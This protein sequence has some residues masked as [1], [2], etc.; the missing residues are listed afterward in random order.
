MRQIKERN[1]AVCII[2]SIVTCGIYAI[3]WLVVM[4]DDLNAVSGHPEDTSGV[5]VM[6]LTIITCG[7]YG[8]YWLYKAGKKLDE[9]DGTGDN[10]VLLLI[11][12]IFGLSIVDYAIIQDRINKKATV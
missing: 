12:A 4:A 2:L 6:L 9:M 11:L 1:I 8:W 3:Y 7:I 5:M 10:S